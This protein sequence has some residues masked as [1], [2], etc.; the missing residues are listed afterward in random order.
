M[1]KSSRVTETEL[2]EISKMR[3]S[4]PVRYNIVLAAPCP[5]MVKFLSIEIDVAV[6]G[7]K[8]PSPTMMISPAVEFVTACAIVAQGEDSP[9]QEPSSVPLEL[10]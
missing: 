9:P 5:R 4:L 2:P 1:V 10:T 8:M 7:K 3:R 6:G